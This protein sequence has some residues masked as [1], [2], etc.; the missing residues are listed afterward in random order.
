MLLTPLAT[1]SQF[2]IV[3]VVRSNFSAPIVGVSLCKQQ[4]SFHS[5]L[6]TAPQSSPMATTSSR[7]LNNVLIKGS[8]WQPLTLKSKKIA[9]SESIRFRYGTKK[10]SHLNH[11]AS[12]CSTYC[13]LGVTNSAIELLQSKLNMQVPVSPEVISDYGGGFLVADLD[14]ASAKLAIGILGPFLSAFAFLFILRIV[15]SWYPKLPVD[16][17]PYVLAYAPTEPFLIVTRK[18]IPPLGG[19]DVTPVVWFGLVSFLNEILLGPQGLLVLISQ[20]VS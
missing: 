9:F 2:P 4:S 17:F 3:G 14:P 20:Q 13:C 18:V 12:W 10:S 11:R 8:V 6:S 16:K 15:M 5:Q 19:V 1:S 7:L